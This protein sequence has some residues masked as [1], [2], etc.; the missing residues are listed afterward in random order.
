MTITGGWSC[1]EDSKW[2]LKENPTAGLP[3]GKKD[4]KM[5]NVSVKYPKTP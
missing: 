4:Y 3:V 1:K 2:E 5:I